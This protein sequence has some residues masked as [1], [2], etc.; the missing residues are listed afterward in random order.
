M[1]DDSVLFYGNERAPYVKMNDDFKERM[2]T[3]WEQVRD[4][5]QQELDSMVRR[6]SR[7][8]D[9]KKDA[10]GE[11]LSA[12]IVAPEKTVNVAAEKTQIQ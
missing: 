12:A 5:K 11:A 8:V 2:R 6:R 10:N 7:S 4:K 1:L 3:A 9:L